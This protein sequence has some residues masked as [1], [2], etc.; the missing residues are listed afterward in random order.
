MRTRFLVCFMFL[1][2]LLTSFQIVNAQDADDLQDYLNQLAAGQSGGSDSRGYLKAASGGETEIDL[3]KFTSYQNRTTALTFASNLNVRITNGT[4]TASPSFSGGTPLVEVYGTVTLDKT[5]GIDASVIYYYDCPAAVGV[6]GSGTFNQYGKVVAPQKGARVTLQNENC[7]WNNYYDPEEPRDYLAFTAV[8][9]SVTIGMSKSGSPNALTL[10]YSSDMVNWTTFTAGTTTFT[11][12]NGETRYMRTA[13]NSVETQVNKSQFD[14]WYYTMTGTGKVSASGNIMSLLDKTCKSTTVGGF[15]FDKLFNGCTSLITAPELPAT[16]LADRC[17]N[18]M[19]A[20]CTSLTTA[21]ELPATTL[22]IM[23]Y[24]DM[25]DGCK[26]LTTAPKLPATTLTYDCYT[27]MFAGCTSLATAPE[28]SATTLADGCYS[29]M[30]RGCTGLT[31]APELPATTLANSCYS[32]MFEGCTSLITAPELP[33]TTITSY[34]YREMFRGCISLKIAPTLPA[35]ILASNCYSGMFNGCSS[36]IKAPELPAKILY[37]NCYESLFANTN[38][39]ELKVS[40]T[41]YVG[42]DLN[43]W[44]KNVTT[45]GVLYVPNAIKDATNLNLPKTWT[46]KGFSE[47]GEYEYDPATDMVCGFNVNTTN[48]FDIHQLNGISDYSVYIDGNRIASFANGALVSGSMSYTFGSEGVHTVTYRLPESVKTLD[49][50]FVKCTSLVSVIIPTNITIIDNYAFYCTSLTTVSIP[51]KV[52]N[53]GYCSFSDCKLLNSIIIPASVKEL[54]KGAF[55]GCESLI[56]I[57]LLGTIPP[58]IYAHDASFSSW[59][60]DNTIVIVPTAALDAYKASDWKKFKNL[61]G[62]EVGLCDYLSFTAVD[63]DVTI[64]MAKKETPGVLTMEYSSDKVNWS[65]FIAGETTFTIPSGETRYLRNA[66]NFLETQVN[67]N[68]RTYWYFTMVGTGK[69][70]AGGNI[71]S[72]LDKTCKSTTVGKYSFYHLFEGCTSLAT[73]PELPATTIADD[74]YSGMFE[75]CTSLATA[76]ELPATTLADGCYSNMF[77]GCTGL[78][79]APKLPATNLVYCCYSYMFR[80]TK[81]CELKVNFTD[82]SA[83]G[84]LD[85]WLA[86]ITTNGVLYVPNEIKNATNLNVPETWLV[87]GLSEEEEYEYNP[88]TDMVCGFNVNTTYSFDIHQL[89]GISDYSVYI[90]GNRIASFANEALVSGSMS[91]TFGSEGVHTVTYRLPES[92]KTLKIAFNE[93]TSLVS[94]IIPTNITSIDVCAFCCTSLTTVS[95]PEKVTNIG[96]YSFSACKSLNSI[97]IPASVKELGKG[98]FVGCTS[99]SSIVLLGTTPPSLYDHNGSFDSWHYENTIVSVPESAL[100]AYQSSDWQLFKSISNA[101]PP[102]TATKDE[103]L[104]MLEKARKALESLNSDYSYLLESYTGMLDYI[105]G[106]YRTKLDNLFSFIAQEIKNYTERYDALAGDQSGD[107]TSIYKN[108]EM[109]YEEIVKRTV[110]FIMDLSDIARNIMDEDARILSERLAALKERVVSLLTSVNKLHSDSR[111][112]ESLCGSDYF[113]INRSVLDDETVVLFESSL[114]DLTE[115]SN[116]VEKLWND[117]FSYVE[118]STRQDIEAFLEDVI[119]LRELLASVEPVLAS[120]QA[121]YPDYAAV[122]DSAELILPRDSVNYSLQQSSFQ[123]YRTSDGFPIQ[124]GYK[125]NRGTVLTS[126]GVM[127][128]E[129]ASARSFYLK[130]NQGNY[131]ILLGRDATMLATDTPEGATQWTG[132]NVGKGNYRIRVYDGGY[133]DCYL[134]VLSKELRVNSE[135]GVTSGSKP[136]WTITESEL[137]ELQAFLN[138]MSEESYTAEDLENMSDEEREAAES[139]LVITFPRRDRRDDGFSPRPFVFPVRPGPVR[140]VGYLPVPYNG[141][142]WKEGEHPVTVPEGSHVILDDVKFDDTE[143]GGDHVIY[144]RGEITVNVTVD[145]TGDFMKRWKWFLV[146]DDGGSVHWYPRFLLYRPSLRIYGGRIDILPGSSAGDIVS[147][148]E[149]VIAR[150]ED[151][152]EPADIS[153]ITNESG[154]SVRQEGGSVTRII[155]RYV[156]VFIGGLVGDLTNERSATFTMT[157]GRIGHDDPSYKDIVIHNYGRFIFSGGYVGGYGSH[158]FYIY[159]GA[160]LRLEGGEIDDTYCTNFIEAYDD[161]YIDGRYNIVKPIIINSGVRIHVIYELHYVWNIRFVGGGTPPL[162][163]PFIVGTRDYDVAL[164][165][166]RR[167]GYEL[168]DR[169]WRW[170]YLPSY[171]YIDEAA[172]GSKVTVRGGALEIAD[173]VV[174]DEDDL[175][176]YL[177]W[178]ASQEAES[179]DANITDYDYSDTEE[180]PTE[181]ILP[182]DKTLYITR[183]IYIPV[184][185]HI[186]LRGGEIR[187]GSY[188]DSSVFVVPYGSWVRTTDVVINLTEYR[189]DWCLFDVAGYLRLGTG[190]YLRGWMPERGFHYDGGLHGHRIHIGDKAEFIYDGGYIENMVLDLDRY[191]YVNVAFTRNIYVNI[192][193][194]CQTRGYQI[195]RPMT[196]SFSLSL[197]DVALLI[198]PDATYRYIFGL[199]KDGCI[200]LYDRVT[201][202]KT[203]R[204][205]LSGWSWL[206]FALPESEPFMS[207]FASRVATLGGAVDRVTGQDGELT[208]NASSGYSGTLKSL[209][210]ASGYHFHAGKDVTLEVSQSAELLSEDVTVSLAKGWNWIGYTPSV[211]LPVSTALSGFTPT[212]GDVIKGRRS[213]AVWHD[214]DWTGSLE[215]LEPGEGYMYMANEAGDLRYIATRPVHQDS[216][217]DGRPSQDDDFAVPQWT[218]SSERYEMNMSIIASFSMD[219]TVQGDGYVIGAFCGNE[220]RGICTRM[221]DGCYYI[222][223]FGDAGSNEVIGFKAF[224]TLTGEVTGIAESLT[225]GNIIVGEP[226]SP[227]ILHSGDPETGINGIGGDLSVEDVFNVGGVMVGG[228]S[229]VDNLNEGVYIMNG[230]KYYLNQNSSR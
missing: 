191:I 46:V 61:Q 229:S 107:W 26:G 96:D 43:D 117:K 193:L 131:L 80:N 21:P 116:S 228:A 69:V 5:A 145:I 130:D 199:D 105:S 70:S 34:C 201:E 108:A 118:L 211:S 188:F 40:F 32:N 137:D 115:A 72:L 86:G 139:E 185:R 148:G 9:G 225:F 140:I 195:M 176:A 15:S 13:S 167:I 218:L 129:R 213:F 48:S 149:V 52:T 95:I 146:T 23:C 125:S 157:G 168:T 88:A 10:E 133:E 208:C 71:M 104:A 164:E 60:Y 169:S 189:Y 182:S 18:Y 187:P 66:S 153:S 47:E 203:R 89:N 76:P 27:F 162:R 22:A 98:A 173:N 134:S 215:R 136:L 219:G 29:Y 151:G 54:G 87:K 175:Q 227:Y 181:I 138:E 106:E 155:N 186:H 55:D 207:D 183:Y 56:N 128:F 214:G 92:V 51:E 45:N 110:T 91:Y 75:G 112:L 126:A 53:I 100:S 179:A 17:Y 109:L 101:T 165:Y 6:L 24:S 154:G 7:T 20:N 124:L 226:E 132:E 198:Q 16:T 190:S 1:A 81:I 113:M 111:A 177:D 224:N 62:T 8:D 50:A 93:C 184:G 68:N 37:D 79:V 36:L 200:A 143:A 121:E 171:E 159:E 147:S 35:M 14:Y 65:T 19:F 210:P 222:T 216:D 119:S 141:V 97:I 85:G 11:I 25:F 38:I 63:G 58:A 122:F 31:V 163:V 174:E 230:K 170:R 94:V 78:T 158:L 39:S 82:Y 150:D 74:C 223:V 33:A 103:A 142:D 114:K 77:E 178:L 194:S 84:C 220:C 44:L 217:A 161:F 135:V 127:Q 57:E 2:A 209:S 102:F 152:S 42:Y 4:I 73:A 67:K 160:Y 206:S 83:K 59:H 212:D 202:Y 196:G 156:Y 192:G 123:N 12:P 204:D 144:V 205:I 180:E 3:S 172:D 64:G 30:F 49:D 28:L 41:N 99:L 197:A 120:V 166:W 221:T 90:D